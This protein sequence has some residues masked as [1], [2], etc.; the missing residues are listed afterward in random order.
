M[1]DC[2]FCRIV[3]RE[4][5]SS[6]VLETAT[7]LAFRDIHPKAPTHVLVIPKK[8]IPSMVELGASDSDLIVDLTRSIQ[9]VAKLE[10]V[11]S[12]GFRVVVNNG[13]AVHQLVGHLHYHVLGGRHLEE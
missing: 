7:T 5:P 11:S 10:N 8:H 9:E 2:L 13:K 12:Q 6:I 4:I 1:S 3:A